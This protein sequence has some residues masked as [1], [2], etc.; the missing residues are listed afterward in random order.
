MI[1][2]INISAISWSEFKRSNPPGEYFV[3][4]E[5]KSNKA[6]YLLKI[7]KNT[8][9]SDGIDVTQVWGFYIGYSNYISYFIGEES[10]TKEK[11]IDLLAKDYPQYLQ[12]FLF[13]EGFING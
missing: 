6:L 1:E 4:S 7:S 12:Y 11:F 13:Q 9:I 8:N 10:I 2:P 3:I 5:S